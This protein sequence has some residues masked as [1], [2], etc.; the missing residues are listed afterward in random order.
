MI[1]RIRISE[2]QRPI[3]AVSGYDGSYGRYEEDY[4]GSSCEG[5]RPNVNDV[6]KSKENTVIN[7]HIVLPKFLRK[8]F[9]IGYSFW[10]YDRDGCCIEEAEPL[11]EGEALQNVTTARSQCP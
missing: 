4:Q 3:G 2:G 5:I 1:R 6:V 9:E 11:Y 10:Y 8:N 7:S